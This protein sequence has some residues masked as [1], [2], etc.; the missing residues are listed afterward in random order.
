MNLFLGRLLLYLIMTLQK[1]EL[2]TFAAGCF[3]GV[4]ATYRQ[5]EGVLK[6]QVGFTGG[7]TKNPTYKDVCTKDTGHAEAIQLSYD[8][9]RV[10]YEQLTEIFFKMHDPTQK[11]R[12]GPD[13][14]SQYRS[15]IFY[16]SEEQKAVAEGL[17]EKLQREKYKSR[18]IVTEIVPAT[19]FYEAE[20]YHQQYFEK[21]GMHPCANYLKLPEGINPFMR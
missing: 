11:N 1:T 10:S 3:W 17:K 8:P 2:A 20:E 19:E 5:V 6:T 18:P 12:Q 9:S 13:V 4:E 21:F 7:R 16:H 15:A 14:G